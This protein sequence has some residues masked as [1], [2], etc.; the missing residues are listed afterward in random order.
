M[1]TIDTHAH[2]YADQFDEDR[3]EM[4]NRAKDAGVSKILLPNIDL[5]SIEGLNK[6]V[7]DYPDYCYKMMGL[8]PCSVEANYKEVLEEIESNIDSNTIAI[9]E[10]G[11][12]LYWDKTT[13]GIQEEAFKI[14]C[15]WAID[16]NLPVAIHSRESTDLIIDIIED[17]FKGDLQG[18]FH[19]FTGTKEQAAR[20]ADLNMYMGLG[21]VLTFKNSGLKDVVP[22]IP[23]ELL[24]LETDSPYLAPTPYRG[25]RNEPAYVVEVFNHLCDALSMDAQTLSTALEANSLKLFRI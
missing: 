16:R 18:V 2:I 7:E 20:I 6:L 17:N 21:G 9:G 19:C 11:I 10:I 24:I 1:V 8:H 3:A 23:L 22:H 4:I 14:Q 5:E 12:D 13:Q 15:Q 25:K